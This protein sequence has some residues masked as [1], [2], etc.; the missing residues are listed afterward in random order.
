MEAYGLDRQ[1]QSRQSWIH[2]IRFA[3]SWCPGDPAILDALAKKLSPERVLLHF[4]YWRQDAYDENYPT[5]TASDTGR[6]FIDRC[7]SMGFRIMPHFNTID[8]DPTNEVY[9]YVRDFQFRTI[10]K[11]QLLGWS[12]YKGRG[13]GVPESNMNRTG[14]RDKKVMVK[15]HPG[16]GM[17]R[18][19]LG[20]RVLDAVNDLSLEAVFMDV[21]L[22]SYNLHNCFVDT[23][24][25]SEG[26]QRLLEHIACLGK[27]LVVG[28]EGLNEIT[29]QSQSFGQVH[30]FNSWHHSVDGLQR[31][32]GCDLNEFLFGSLCRSF[33]YS[34][35]GG[36]NEDEE[37]RMRIHIEHGAIPT[38]TIRSAK[39]ISDPNP[40]V[41]RMLDMAV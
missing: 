24:T 5:Y 39:D 2:D 34:G 12:W 31:A 10:E 32:G 14:N 8:M 28:G 25:S 7:R 16:L 33:G 21:A 17:W 36:R 29:A 40:A 23:M 9:P 22:H 1:E 11:Q 27:G 4:P 37:L 30:L 41:K 3:V 6:N 26:M 13:I 18:S 15:I 38:V 35:L 19:I 20:G